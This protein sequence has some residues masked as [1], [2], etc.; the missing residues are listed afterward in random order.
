MTKTEYES[1]QRMIPS[2]RKFWPISGGIPSLHFYQALRRKLFCKC[3][4]VQ[5][6]ILIPIRIAH[7]S[8]E[9]TLIQDEVYFTC[10]TLFCRGRGNIQKHV[11][12]T[13]YVCPFLRNRL[14]FCYFQI[15][16][17]VF[18]VRNV[19]VKVHDVAQHVCCSHLSGKLHVF[20]L[21]L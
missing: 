6:L 14:S 8:L 7:C 4:C 19:F 12:V 15:I 17:N 16:N 10:E 18:V 21:P 3:T 1:P 20:R 9:E 13:Q 11:I 2:K 5:V